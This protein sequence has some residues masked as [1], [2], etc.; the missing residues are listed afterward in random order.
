MNKDYQKELY[1]I[2]KRKEVQEQR[3][4]FCLLIILAPIII[5]F[6]YLSI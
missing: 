3:M 4:G 1:E 2:A 5:F 6:I